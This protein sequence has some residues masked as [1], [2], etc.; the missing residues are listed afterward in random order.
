MGYSLLGNNVQGTLTAGINNSVTAMN[1]T[2]DAGSKSYPATVSADTPLHLTISDPDNPLLNEIVKVTAVS[3]A[4][5]T[6]M[7]RG[8]RGT[9]ALTWA[10]DSKVSLNLHSQD[11]TERS[12]TLNPAAGTVGA[13]SLFFGADTTTGAYRSAANIFAFTVSGVRVADFRAGAFETSGINA[14]FRGDVAIRNRIYSHVDGTEHAIFQGLAG[15]GTTASPTACN[16]SDNM[17]QIQGWGY[18]TGV[19]YGLSASINFVAS[20]NHGAAAI[21]SR[22]D[23]YTTPVTTETAALAMRINNTKALTLYGDAE[24]PST[25]GVHFGGLTTA[26]SWRIERDG[27]NLVFQRYESSVWVTKLTIED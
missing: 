1:V 20:E 2:L 26:G 12:D 21:G 18:K 19:G 14:N 23:F 13:P 10:A 17:F 3:G 4:N 25:A 9:S 16:S 8:Q 7:V 6:T 15:R 27:D 11:M 5:V 22:I 24:L